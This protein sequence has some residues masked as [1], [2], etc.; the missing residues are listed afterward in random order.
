VVCRDRAG[1]Y[2]EAIRTG[3]PQAV[4][5]ADWFR[6]WQNLCEAAGKTAAAH[7]CCLRACDPGTAPLPPPRAY[8]LAERTRARHAAV[9]DLL[10]HGLSR[11]AVARELNL[12]L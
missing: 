1:A 12:G 11:N 8:R 7:H 4:Q 2:A 9:H 5:L 3:A 6:L 10:A